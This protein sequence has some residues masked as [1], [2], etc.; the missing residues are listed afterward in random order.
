MRSLVIFLAGFV[1]LFLFDLSQIYQKKVLTR[2][3]SIIGNSCI[4]TGLL[5]LLLSFKIDTVLS[6]VFIAKTVGAALFFMLL[7]YSVFIEIGIKTPY[8]KSNRRV[9]LVTGTYGFVRHPGF[10]WFLLLMLI[11]MS[12]YMNLEFSL[13]GL[14]VICMNFILILLED[15]ILFPKIFINYDEYKKMVPFIIPRFR[16]KRK[17]VRST[18][19]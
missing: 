3:C 4:I 17:T 2:L 5:L 6:A 13:I 9:A 8:S 14:S 19:G 18:N 7:V 15:I 16:H 11:L 1:L 10:L 12:I